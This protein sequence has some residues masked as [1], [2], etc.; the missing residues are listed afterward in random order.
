MEADSLRRGR[1]EMR[2]R[3]AMKREQ[4]GSAMSQPRYSTRREEIIT[5]TLPSVSANTWRNT[6]VAGE[7]LNVSYGSVDLIGQYQGMRTNSD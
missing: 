2:I 7:R 3:R 4:I 5:P 1:T 6:P